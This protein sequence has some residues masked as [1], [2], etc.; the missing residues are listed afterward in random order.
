MGCDKKLADSQF[1]C[2]YTSEWEDLQKV[3]QEL[4]KEIEKKETNWI[5]RAEKRTKLL[6]HQELFEAKNCYIEGESYFQTSLDKAFDSFKPDEI[7]ENRKRYS[8]QKLEISLIRE[9]Q[10]KAHQHLK[11]IPDLKNTIEWLTLMQHYEAPT[12]LLDWSYSFYVALFF[13]LTRLDC[14][15]EY[16]EVWAVNSR[17]VAMAEEKIYTTNSL[18]ELRDRRKK[19][20]INMDEYHNEL[21]TQLSEHPQPLVLVLNSFRLNDRLIAQKG[22]FLVQGDID[23]SFDNN[24]KGMGQEDKDFEKQLH[25]IVISVELSKRNKILKELSKMNIN[26]A[27]LFPGL[28]GF[29]ESLA[30]QLADPDKFGIE[31]E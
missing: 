5:F 16:A 29:G 21:L 1:T 22:T 9:F 18:H 2:Y 7:D 3:Y 6:N 23:K 30:S 31:K 24:L 11:Y 15:K 13:A 26:N 12:R 4:P 17:W 28:Q 20:P 27:T 25:R 10:R 8:R 14:E 19:D